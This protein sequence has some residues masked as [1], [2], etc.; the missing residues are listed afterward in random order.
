MDSSTILNSILTLDDETEAKTA[1]GQVSKHRLLLWLVYNV[2]SYNVAVKLESQ[3]KFCG[4]DILLDLKE[5]QISVKIDATAHKQADFLQKC[6]LVPVKWLL[7]NW[8]TECLSLFSL[9]QL[10]FFSYIT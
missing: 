6:I 4:L 8:S 9:T 3:G 10:H 7:G 2:T 5:K 1:K